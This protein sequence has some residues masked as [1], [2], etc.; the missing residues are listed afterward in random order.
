MTFS[1][2]AQDILSAA[3]SEA[4]QRRHEYFTSEHVLFAS[5]H[6]DGPRSIL[7]ECGLF[8]DELREH[9]SRYLEEK[10]PRVSRR[11]PVQSLGFRNV[12]ERATLHTQH[13]GKEEVNAADVLVSIFD[14]DRSFGSFLLRQKGLTRLALLEVVSHG[15]FSL[16]DGAGQD[17]DENQNS[18]RENQDEYN[19]DPDERPFLENPG[20]NQ[21]RMHHVSGRRDILKEF[22]SDLTALAAEGK[23]EPLIGRDD[24]VERT[25]QVLVRRLKNNPLH[26]GEPGVGKTAITEGLAS[27]IVEGRVPDILKAYRILS[28]DM[29]TMVAGTRYRGD[30]EERMKAVVA[31]LV[32]EEKIILFIDEIHTLVGAG[33]VS[34]GSMDAS[35]MLK[36]ALQ[37][38]KLRCIGS[39]T[40]EE[41]RKFFERDRALARRF[42]KIEVAEPSVEETVE[43]LQGLKEKYEEYHS[44]SYSGEAL[45]AAADLSAKLINDR[46]LPDKAI[47][48]VDEAGAWIRMHRYREGEEQEP[49]TITEADVEKV[50]A[51]IA[52]VPEKSVSFS[53]KE[54]LR[55]LYEELKKRIYGQDEPLKAVVDAVKRSRAGFRNPNKPVASFLFVGPTG[56][57]KTELA[58]SLADILGITLLRFDMSE[59]QEK[60]TVSRLIGSPPGYVGYEEGGL[61]SEAVR[62]TPHAVLLLDE[63]EKAHQDI[64]NVLLQVMDY[65]TITDN[66]GKKAD[67]RNV[68]LIMT[69]NAGARDIGRPL[70]GFGDAAVGKS[71][72]AQ[73]VERLFTPEFRNRLDRVIIFNNLDRE[74]VRNIVLKEIGAFRAQLVEKNVTL[75]VSEDA[76]SLLLEEGYS[77]E[78][79]ARNIARVVEEKVKDFF[80]E[81]VLFGKLSG[82]GYAKVGVKDGAIHIETTIETTV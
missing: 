16:E 37:S 13:A 6:F 40:F 35:N 41:C 39:T 36:P 67:F 52:R 57:G 5:L 20:E 32:K 51:K 72:V 66:A 69:S 78:F 25:I 81:E 77:R 65:A 33:A 15:G 82:G 12:I 63:I 7:E 28:L 3:Y 9:M 18:V 48:V 50:V 71:V 60:H 79:G 62:K 11:E 1:Q 74:I 4:K 59:Y 19:P 21:G 47:D 23:L 26:V 44:V 75:E 8:P 68:I 42:Q 43:I 30:F 2:E 46:F 80:I 64:F 29:G 73:A 70:I 24:L 55:N 56:V 31:R 10:V 76:V 27:R 61:L 38:G 49:Y 22:T 34:G 58:R 14:E 54:Q 17:G 45:R 53:E